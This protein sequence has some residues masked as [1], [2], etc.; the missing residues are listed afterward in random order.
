MPAQNMLGGFSM[1]STE[2]GIVPGSD[3]FIYTP[4]TQAKS[5]F[6]YPFI[7]GCF[8]YEPGYCLRRSSFDSFLIMYIKKGRCEIDF[9]NYHYQAQES[10]I[11]ILDCYS[12][13][14]Y[15]S[16][17]GWEAEWLHF[18]GVCAKG[19]Y[20]A[21]TAGKGPVITLASTCRLFTYLHQIYRQFKDSLPI[22]EALLNNYLVNI[23]TEM[24][25]GKDAWDTFPS[26]SIIEDSIA[27]INEHIT[28]DLTLDHLAAQA[29]LSPF[30]FSRLFKK[31]TGFSPHNYIITTRIN[32]AKYLLRTSDASVK[33]ICFET[34]FTSE[35]SFC[36]AFRRE[37]GLSPSQYRRQTRSYI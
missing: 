21:I 32:N 6:L 26:L 1:L 20:E 11:V 36:T 25:I 19:Y 22:K 33:T 29:T 7:T 28:Q 31:E 5:L 17:D 2:P 12:P 4:S 37:T 35:S 8:R 14:S 27:Y 10:Q 15:Y 9:E 34:G 3:Y 13:H 24:L 23:L 30:Y 16:L 18:D